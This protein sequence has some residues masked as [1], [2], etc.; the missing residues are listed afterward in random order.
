MAGFTPMS[1]AARGD[2]WP[3]EL[4]GLSAAVNQL[5]RAVSDAVVAENV[6]VGRDE[7]PGG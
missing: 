6:A 3:L 1:F 7:E 4:P 5:A 2:E